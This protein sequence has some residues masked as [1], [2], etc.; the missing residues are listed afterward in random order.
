MSNVRKS[1]KLRTTVL[2]PPILELL[3]AGASMIGVAI[4]RQVFAGNTDVL[5]YSILALGSFAVATLLS[6]VGSKPRPWRAPVYLALGG[7]MLGAFYALT[8]RFSDEYYLVALIPLGGAFLIVGLL[9]LVRGLSQ[10]S[11]K[12]GKSVDCGG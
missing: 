6:I 12:E 1:T 4:G 8:P 5:F 10:R 9:S 3:G 2:Q 7:A 11:T